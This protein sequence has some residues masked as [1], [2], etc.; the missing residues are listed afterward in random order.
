[1]PALFEISLETGPAPA[2]GPE[3]LPPG[4]VPVTYSLSLAVSCPLTLVVGRLGVFPFPAGRYAY[5]GSSRRNIFARLRR[6][7]RREKKLRWHIDYLLADSAVCVSGL[8]LSVRPECD[9]VAASGG[10]VVVPGFGASD[11]RRGCGSHLRYF[12]S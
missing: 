7:L 12:G 11:C 9:L 5:I 1:M 3:L 10:R 2:L 8:S 6:H 4:F